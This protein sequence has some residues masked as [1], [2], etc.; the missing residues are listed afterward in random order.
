MCFYRA[1]FIHLRCFFQ[2]RSV[3]FRQTQGAR[4]NTKH[5][6]T[7]PPF[8][9]V[10]WYRQRPVAAAPFFHSSPRCRPSYGSLLSAHAYLPLP[11][12]RRSL[13]ALA[14]ILA[15]N[16]AVREGN[17]WPTLAGPSPPPLP[18]PPPP[19]LGRSSR[20]SIPSVHGASPA[21][22]L[23]HP[24][25]VTVTAAAI[26]FHLRLPV[27]LPMSTTDRS[28]AGLPPAVSPSRRHRLPPGPTTRR[29]YYEESRL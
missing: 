17:K 20:T 9:S 18:P 4:P 27:P 11:L 7:S 19:S 21:V 29:R 6:Y 15:I 25:S 5:K 14:K 3:F 2:T 24:A 12:S 22:L 1:S 26:L 23:G 28:L 10:P 16:Y 13:R 8:T